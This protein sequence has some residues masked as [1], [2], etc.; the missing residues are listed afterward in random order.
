MSP[1][2]VNEDRKAATARGRRGRKPGGVRALA[3]RRRRL[4]GNELIEQLNEMIAQLISENRKLK[5]QVDKLTARG[6]AAASST[7]E[8]GLRTIQRRVQKAL[9]AAPKRRR[10]RSTATAGAAKTATR[11][12]RTTK[13]A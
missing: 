5:R 7:V 9:G 2:D 10:R 8:R 4:A 12:R 6:S 13:K 3:T 11:R 1:D